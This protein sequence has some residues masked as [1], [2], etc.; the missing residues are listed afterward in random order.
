MLADEDEDAWEA[1]LT[2]VVPATVVTPVLSWATEVETPAV[3]DVP[4][5]AKNGIA[6]QERFTGPGRA[7]YHWTCR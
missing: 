7:T 5:A 6:R 3:G 4:E 1:E 2:T